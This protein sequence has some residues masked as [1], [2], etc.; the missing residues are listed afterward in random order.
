VAISSSNC[1]RFE[2]NQN[3]GHSWPSDQNYPSVVAHQMIFLGGADG[4]AIVLP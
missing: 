4:S 2:A 3:N 1:P